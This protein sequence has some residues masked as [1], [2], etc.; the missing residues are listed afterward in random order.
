MQ[1]NTRQRGAIR[2]AFQRAAR[3]LSPSEVHA[4]ARQDVAGLG[5]ATVYRS[6]RRL[7]DEGWLV[8]VM[9]PGES[10][11]YEIAGQPHHHHF[12]C[13]R[14]HR[15]FDIPCGGPGAVDHAPQG[16]T[17][18]QHDVVLLGTCPDCYG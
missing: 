7:L 2:R 12:R 3:P 13:E 8:T 4:L 10:S 1:R 5:V 11:R 18:H 17:V 16:F 6:I 14:C 9:L 15:V